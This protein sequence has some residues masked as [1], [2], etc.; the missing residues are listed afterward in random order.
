[1]KEIGE[2]E[3]GSRKVREEL[4]ADLLNDCPDTRTMAN[5]QKEDGHEQSCPEYFTSCPLG[6]I[7]CIGIG[8]EN[9]KD[10]RRIEGTS[11]DPY[12]RT[13]TVLLEI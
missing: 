4:H 5:D 1:M 10:V 9:L 8:G 13:S 3:A 6:Q 7:W 2:R 11:E 12:F